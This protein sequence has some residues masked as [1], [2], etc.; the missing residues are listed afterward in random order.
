MDKHEIND[1]FY[2]DDDAVE[3]ERLVEQLLEQCGLIDE[4]D[5]STEQTPPH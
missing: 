2:L 5:I 4:E 1:E 3:L